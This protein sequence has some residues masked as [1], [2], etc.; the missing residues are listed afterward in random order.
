L[1]YCSTVSA[2]LECGYE[3]KG[4]ACLPLFRTAASERYL[5]RTTSMKVLREF[6]ALE[7]L[8]LN[9]HALSSMQAVLFSPPLPRFR[10]I[11]SGFPQWL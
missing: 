6:T 9:C 3:L 4:N 11:G 5:P 1:Q 10:R 2:D 7:A 8:L